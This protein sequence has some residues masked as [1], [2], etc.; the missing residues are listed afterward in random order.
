MSPFNNFVDSPEDFAQ[1][2][3]E[4][5]EQILQEVQEIAKRI[6]QIEIALSD[7]EILYSV[8]VGEKTKKDNERWFSKHRAKIWKETLK[9]A[10]GDEEKAMFTYGE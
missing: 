4:R 6:A 3:Q 8:V 2:L 9:K 10:N 7:F 1:L 5:N